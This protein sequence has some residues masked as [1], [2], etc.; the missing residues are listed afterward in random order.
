[1]SDGFLADVTLGPP[2]CRLSGD[3]RS[4]VLQ[5]G[6]T[7]AKVTVGARRSVDGWLRDAYPIS[8]D[9]VELHV[10]NQ[11]ASPALTSA[12]AELSRSILTADRHCRRV[13]FA[14]SA[15]DEAVVA[16]AR[17]A[18]FRYVLDVDVPGAELTLLVVEPKW[19]TDVDSGLD[20]VPDT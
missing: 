12:L 17:A 11:S 6:D 16:A 10:T 5:Y 9:D 8:L 15:R 19:V 18:G 4:V 3:D 2:W 1:M 20:D 14:A 7:A 13:V